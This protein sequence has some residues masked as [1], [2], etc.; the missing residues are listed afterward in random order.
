MDQLAETCPKCFGPSFPGKEAEE[1]DYIV[2]M[3][4][5]FQHRQHLAASI[6]HS[7]IKTPHLFI[8]PD[9]INDQGS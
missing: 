2:C 8:K 1:P 9:E 4:G 3:D 7:N 5:N 6:E